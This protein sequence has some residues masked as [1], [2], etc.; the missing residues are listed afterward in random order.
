MNERE[1]NENKKRGNGG[2]GKGDNFHVECALINLS[3]KEDFQYRDTQA[4]R[5]PPASIGSQRSG[6]CPGCTT[7]FYRCHVSS[8]TDPG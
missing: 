6:Q 8:P 5:D 3:A 4:P 1:G 2:V 7:A